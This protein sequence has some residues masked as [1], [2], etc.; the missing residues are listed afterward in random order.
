MPVYVVPVQVVRYEIAPDPAD[1]TNDLNLRHLWRSA[2]GGRTAADNFANTNPPPGAQW[3]LVARG[4]QDLQ[5]TYAD[6]DTL[7]PNPPLPPG[8]RPSP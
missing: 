2:T 3:Q 4:I 8:T 1:P 5:V 7:A 6:G